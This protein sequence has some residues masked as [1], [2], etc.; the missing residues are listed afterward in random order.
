MSVS[1]RPNVRP[2]DFTTE[3]EEWSR[4]DLA[5]NSIL[6]VKF[7]LTQV[8]RNNDE[9]A[10]DTSRLYIVLTNERG[11]PDA[12][13]RTPQEVQNSITNRNIRFTTVLQDW[14]EYVLDDGSRVRIQPMVNSVSK[15]SLFDNHGNPVYWVEVLQST[16]VQKPDPEN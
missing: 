5:D 3:R 2:L 8:R 11:E 14:N 13:V 9:Y 6:K 12:R 16:Q 4:Y 10:V 15:T 1:D 7:V